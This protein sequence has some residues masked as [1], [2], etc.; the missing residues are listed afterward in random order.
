MEKGKWGFYR[1]QWIWNI[2]RNGLFIM[3]L[4][5]RLE[6]VGLD[7]DPYYWE[8][9]G[10]EFSKVPRIKDDP[11]LYSLQF[12]AY[13]EVEKLADSIVG[14]DRDKLLG[15]MEKGQQCIGLRYHT[16]AVAA[17]ML[18]ET[19]A[20]IYKHRTVALGGHEAY[21]LGMYTFQAFRGKNLAPFLRYKS[22]EFLGEQGRSRL[23]SIT[24]Y[25]NNS[26]LKFKRKLGVRHLSL[27]MYIGLFKKLR[28]NFRIR[29]YSNES[30]IV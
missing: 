14:M 19:N 2:I 27:R 5:N 10:L 7:F 6:K 21:L 20:V 16:G 26:S 24:A 22:Y 8:L 4:R 1:L 29:N 28:W 17:F 11:A 23:Y 25:F 9:E 12:L 18:I 13:E 15:G 3:G 30:G